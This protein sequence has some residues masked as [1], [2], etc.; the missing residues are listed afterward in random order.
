MGECLELKENYVKLDGNSQVRGLPERHKKSASGRT[1][2]KQ[3]I[4][5]SGYFDLHVGVFACFEEYF[6]FS[7]VLR[8]FKY[9]RNQSLQGSS[10]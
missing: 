8:T 5:T 6:Y 4:N 9:N 7:F 3:A 1:K 2:S 10:L